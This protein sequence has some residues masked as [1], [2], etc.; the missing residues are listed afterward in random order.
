MSDSECDGVKKKKKNQKLLFVKNKG[1]KRG[2]KKAHKSASLFRIFDFVTVEL[3]ILPTFIYA[4]IYVPAAI[5]PPQRRRRH[6][7]APR[8]A[9]PGSA[10]PGSAPRP[11]RLHV[12]VT[13]PQ[14]RAAGGMNKRCEIGCFV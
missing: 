6:R 7:R 10:R 13:P 4:F 12:P 11:A 14:G 1:D 2:K 5:V 8:P 9:W 3:P